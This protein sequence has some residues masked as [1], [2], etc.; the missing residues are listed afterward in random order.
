MVGSIDVANLNAGNTFIGNKDVACNVSTKPT[1]SR[2]SLNPENL[3]SDK[4][5]SFK[6]PKPARF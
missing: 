4:T 6:K 3:G 2:K 1:Q 5:V